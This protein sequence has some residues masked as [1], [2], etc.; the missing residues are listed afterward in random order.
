MRRQLGRSPRLRHPYDVT[1]A[2]PAFAHPS[3]VLLAA[4]CHGNVNLDCSGSGTCDASS[5]PHVCRCQS[6]RT[7]DQCQIGISFSAN[8][9]LFLTIVIVAASCTDACN[10]NGLCDDNSNSC[11]CFFGY[12]GA[13]CGTPVSMVVAND[14][15]DALNGG[16]SAPGTNSTVSL[17][18]FESSRSLFFL[19]A[20]S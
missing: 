1:P 11:S 5:V 13:S 2:P 3:W 19:A 4:I 17:R 10:G 12:T 7:G 8:S 18:S 9:C 16:G 6:G 15:N 14:P 20:V